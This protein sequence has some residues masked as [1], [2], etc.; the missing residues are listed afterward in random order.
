MLDRN[1]EVIFEG[2]V[3]ASY[4]H[5]TGMLLTTMYMSVHINENEFTLISE[6]DTLICHGFKDE[7]G[8]I[9]FMCKNDVKIML[10]GE[11]L[12]LDE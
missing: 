8:G 11:E 1:I 4:S 2:K 6:D 10:D 9:R 12:D 5:R 7:E 3:I